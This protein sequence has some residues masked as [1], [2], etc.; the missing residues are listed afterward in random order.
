MDLFYFNPYT[1][2]PFTT[3]TMNKQMHTWLTVYCTVLYFS[4]PNVP[5]HTR[6]PKVDIREVG[7]EGM[8][9]IEL[10]QV[11]HRW[12]AFVNVAMNLRVP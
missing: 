10:A 1:V 12:R 5:T 2:R 3:C 4:L 11:R 7:C 6:H 9:W 8:D